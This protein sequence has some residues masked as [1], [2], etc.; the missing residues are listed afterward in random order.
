MSSEDLENNNSSGEIDDDA[1]VKDANP[2]HA[3]VEA[4][5]SKE[6]KSNQAA[7]MEEVKSVATPDEESEVR[8]RVT[9]MFRSIDIQRRRRSASTVRPV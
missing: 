4:E 9:R 3:S 5:E 2:I 8:A 7:S 6:S 1:T